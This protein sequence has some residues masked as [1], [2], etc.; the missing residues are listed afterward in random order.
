MP[1]RL[2]MV[3]DQLEDCEQVKA[4]FDPDVFSIEFEQEPLKAVNRARDTECALVI[5]DIVMT[6]IDG[7]DVIRRL[8]QNPYTGSLPIIVFSHIGDEDRV[9]L[10]SLGLGVDHIVDKKKPG[11]L[12]LLE[13]RIYRLLEQV[14][15][16]RNSQ[17]IEYTKFIVDEHMLVLQ[18]DA[19]RVWLDDI[20]LDL[21]LHQRDILALIAKRS[22]RGEYTPTDE[23]RDY[24]YQEC[25]H[26]PTWHTESPNNIYRFMHALRKRL[27]SPS[28]PDCVFLESRR[29][30]GYRVPGYTP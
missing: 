27:V 15:A 10:Q 5:V 14:Q 1:H 25:L 17:A 26:Y 22:I 20:E 23:I 18:G 4:Y 16:S 8:Q 29:S 2:L 13:A 12:R 19:T 21:S 9:I 11:A 3:D 28:C 6:P 7:F 30:L 24:Y